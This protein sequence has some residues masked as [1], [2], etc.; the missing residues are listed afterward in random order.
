[1]A[2]NHGFRE[3]DFPVCEYV[4][5]RTLALPFSGKL[6]LAQVHRVCDR[7]DRLLEQALISRKG[8]L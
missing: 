6:T 8:R 2:A 4:A 1:M 5:A 3:G 7:L